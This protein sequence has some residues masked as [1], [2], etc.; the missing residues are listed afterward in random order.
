MKKKQLIRYNFR[1]EVFKRDDYRCRC[2]GIKDVK[3]DAHHIIDRN[4]MPN[5]GYVKENGIS[6][7]EPCH[8]KAEFEHQGMEPLP[9][10]SRRELFLLINSNEKLARYKSER[11]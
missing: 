2:C 3:L 7:C 11:L 9:G 5:G 10:Y 8:E 4:N 6:L 1:E